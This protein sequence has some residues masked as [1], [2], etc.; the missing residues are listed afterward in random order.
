MSAI[1]IW[2]RPA[3][4]ALVLSPQATWPA[5]PEAGGQNNVSGDQTD[6]LIRRLARPPPATIAFTEVRFSPLLRR[7]LIVSGEL[8]YAGPVDLDR[9]VTQ[10]YREYTAIRG[11]SVRVER[12]G[13]PVRTF[14][15]K[16]A[17]ELRGLLSGFSALLTGD[18]TSLRRSF[19]IDSQIAAD[20]AWA[21]TM[22]PVDAKARRRV[23]QL[24]AVGSDNEPR[25]FTL[26]TADGGTSVMLLGDAASQSIPDQA[27]AE[28]LDALCKKVSRR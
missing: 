11:E 6:Q 7:P 9:R 23:T 15:L 16:R 28:Q 21:I 10:P 5:T 8:G 14:A 3:L 25:C 26:S 4:L 12:E 18:A 19:N 20:D 24:S 27:T 22:T 2:I 17:P 13:E 1:R